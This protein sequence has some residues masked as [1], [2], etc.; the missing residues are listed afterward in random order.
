[1][2]DT[3]DLSTVV[4]VQEGGPATRLG[5]GALDGIEAWLHANA[6]L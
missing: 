2:D 1:M 3:T 6:G 5:I 4:L